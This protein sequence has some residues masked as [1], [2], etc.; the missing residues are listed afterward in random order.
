MK[1]FVIYTGYISGRCRK[2]W[3]LFLF[4]CFFCFFFSCESRWLWSTIFFCH[5]L[6]LPPPPMITIFFLP[7]FH[8]PTFL[9]TFVYSLY[10]WTNRTMCS[11]SSL[12]CLFY[13]SWF[14]PLVIHLSI[15]HHQLIN[16][17]IIVEVDSTNLIRITLSG[18]TTS[19]SMEGQL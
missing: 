18:W 3:F 11:L 19:L 5:D 8:R 15:L 17:D 1:V 9:Y 12:L 4:V 13:C 10:D 16:Y 7:L 14:S 2:S 6:S